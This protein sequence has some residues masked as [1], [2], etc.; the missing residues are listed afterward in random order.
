M[1]GKQELEDRS[2]EWIPQA[3]NLFGKKSEQDVKKHEI[4]IQEQNERRKLRAESSERK[5]GW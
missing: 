5:D 4:S 3:T 2:S 1:K